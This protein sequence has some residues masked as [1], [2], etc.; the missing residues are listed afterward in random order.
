MW[1]GQVFS[2]QQ[3]AQM[4]SN[5][6][7][8]TYAKVWSS[9]WEDTEDESYNSVQIN[10]NHPI[11]LTRVATKALLKRNKRGVVLI[12]ASIAGYSGHFTSPL[13]SATKHALVGFTRSIG[14]LDRLGGVKVVTICPG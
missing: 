3:V 13:Y 14:E 10:V 2:S 6:V 11:K 8:L 9:F 4:E 1:L 7:L 12:M 5:P